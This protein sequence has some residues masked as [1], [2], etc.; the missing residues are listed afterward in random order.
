MIAQ[1]QCLKG[2]SMEEKILMTDREA[3]K[4]LSIGRTTLWNN[5]KQ[6]V[7]PPPIKIGGS[8]R[9]RVA[10]LLDFVANVPTVRDDGDKC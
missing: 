9:W 7:I 2:L 3:A 8:T 6:G 4:L 1:S 5:V 10:D